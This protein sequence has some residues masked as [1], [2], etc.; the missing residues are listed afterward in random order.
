MWVTKEG[1]SRMHGGKVV[2]LNITI[3]TKLVKDLEIVVQV[4]AAWEKRLHL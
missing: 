4:H 1:G 3:Q 2:R